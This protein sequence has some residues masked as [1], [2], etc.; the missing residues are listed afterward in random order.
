MFYVSALLNVW[1]GYT[2]VFCFPL[3]YFFIVFLCEHALDGH[4]AIVLTPCVFCSISHDMVLKIIK[5]KMW[6]TSVTVMHTTY[7]Y[8]KK[9]GHLPSSLVFHWSARTLIN[10]E[11]IC[12]SSTNFTISTKSL[13][14][15]FFLLNGYFRHLDLWQ[16]T[17]RRLPV[18]FKPQGSLL[19]PLIIW[20]PP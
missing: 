6:D 18:W 13:S 17:Q 14:L 12:C 11:K 4:L 7:G 1:A 9:F 20:K 19:G 3:R 5:K 16:H 8:G 2:E 10:G 15:F